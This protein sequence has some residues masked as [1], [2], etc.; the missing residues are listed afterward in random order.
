MIRP[1]GR[2][3]PSHLRPR[4]AI[5][6]LT[7]L[8][9]RATP[10]TGFQ[11]A[12]AAPGAEPYVTV[13]RPDGS[14]LVRFL[15]YDDA[16]RGGVRAALAPFAANPDLLEV[17]T[18]AGPGGGPHVR[19]F[20]VNAVTGAVAPAAGF[21]AYDPMFA[22][23][24]FVAAGD[25]TGDGVPDVVTGAGPGG[26]PHVEVFD[27]RT[28]AL[29]KGFMAFDPGFRGGASVAVGEL[30]GRAADG[31]ELAVAAGP[32]GGPHVRV[33]RSDGTQFAGFFA[34]PL[35]FTGGVTLG[36]AG[37]GWLVA[38]AGQPGSLVAAGLFTLASDGTVTATAIDPVAAPGLAGQAAGSGPAT[39]PGP[40]AGAGLP[41]WDGREAQ[42]EARAQQGHANILFLGDSITDFLQNG[43][44]QPVWDQSFAPLG[45][46]DFAVGGATTSQVLWQV[47][48]GQVAALTPDV[49]VLLIGTNN[50]GVLGQTP[51]E[52]AAGVAAIVDQIELQLPRTRILLLGVLPRGQDPTDPLRTSAAQA[53]QMIA[54]L[55]DG[56]R[57][58]YLDIGPTFL[59]PD[60][61]IAPVVMPDFL[62]PSLLGYGLFTAAIQPA[63]AAALAG[64]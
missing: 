33:L 1:R 44:G 50:L 43:A 29:L 7:A 39:A 63:L 4:R 58:R 54:Q 51:A 16:F 45:A 56:R 25:L 62:H 3:P 14:A 15:A 52:V 41:Y 12:E 49:V 46:A 21:F 26:G 32:S 30:D 8:E 40:L 5:L 42:N 57:V 60:G 11:A 10:D 19:V 31:P 22:G 9:D 36:Q 28:G 61:T 18:G 23:G 37:Q 27:G 24:V 64:L 20:G 13:L 35:G 2:R 53:N 34:Y 47:Q 17:V 59:Q 48:T 38:G 6:R 55:G